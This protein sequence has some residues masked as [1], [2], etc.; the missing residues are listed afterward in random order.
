MDSVCVVGL[1]YVG[2]PLMCALAKVRKVVGFDVDREK[3]NQIEALIGDGRISNT[4]VT[5][6]N[7][8]LLAN[9]SIYFICVPTPLD[10]EKRPDLT[11]VALACETIGSVLKEGDTVVLESTVSPGTTDGLCASILQKVS[12]LTVDEQFHLG[13]SP[14]RVNPGDSYHSVTSVAKIVSG[15]TTTARDAIKNIYAEILC[16]PIIEAR[17]VKEAEMAKLVENTQRDV[18]IAFINELALLLMDTDLDMQHILELARSKWNF[19]DF[20][21]GLVGGHCISVDPYYLCSYANSIGKNLDTVSL[22]R[23]VNDSMV[24]VIISAFLNHAEMSVTDRKVA[25]MGATFK[26]DIDDF[27]NSQQVYLIEKLVSLGCLVSVYEPHVSLD[28]F[29]T[30]TGLRGLKVFESEAVYDAIFVCVAHSEILRNGAD[31]IRDS[32]ASDGLRYVMDVKSCLPS[33][34]VDSSIC[35]QSL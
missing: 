25:V 3:I 28:E 21:P 14:E 20:R 8:D 1:G 16:A 22:A 5:N 2:F 24:D 9:C 13:F 29:M 27:R 23:K 26:E 17:S 19:C 33:L 15:R 12:G 10:G 31:L 32:L 4:V 30:A 6:T 7:L 11:A 34:K 18:N 35:Y